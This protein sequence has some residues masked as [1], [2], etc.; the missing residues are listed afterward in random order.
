MRLQKITSR[1]PGPEA[2]VYDLRRDPFLQASGL[3]IPR[4]P[5]SIW[6]ILR[7]H[8]CIAHAP[9]RKSRPQELRNPG[10]EVQLDLKDIST[11]PP[12]PDGKRVH[13]IES[14]HIVD[15]GTSIWLKRVVRGDFDAETL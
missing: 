11:V 5:T 6:K 13:V 4:S 10:E 12:D 9:R 1:V 15:A 3:P 8:G 2:I 14:C 7:Q